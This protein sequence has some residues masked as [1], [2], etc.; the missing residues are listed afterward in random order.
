MSAESTN[1]AFA[2]ALQAQHHELRDFLHEGTQL[3][4]DTGWAVDDLFSL[5]A[6]LRRHLREHFEHEEQ[7]GYFHEV[8]V[9][10]PQLA[11]RANA[12]LEQHGDFMATLDGLLALVGTETLSSVS[13]SEIESRWQR[14]SSEFCRHEAGEVDL[15]QFVFNEDLGSGD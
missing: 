4:A 2:H 10:R 6:V 1:P 14:F 7:G 13:R 11:P 3:L 5:L 12:L 15:L 8:I 9:A